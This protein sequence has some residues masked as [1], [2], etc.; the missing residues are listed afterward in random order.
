[1]ASPSLLP[2]QILELIGDIW[3]PLDPDQAVEWRRALSEMDLE[4]AERAALTL[5]DAHPTRPSLGLFKATYRGLGAKQPAPPTE[6][7]KPF[8]LS[9]FDEQRAKL[10]QAESHQ[11]R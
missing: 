7:V 4:V 3:H 1:M 5:R 9:W 6:P 8:D 10:R 2:D 11:G